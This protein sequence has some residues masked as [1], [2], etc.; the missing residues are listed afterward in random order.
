MVQKLVSDYFGREAH[1]RVNPDEV[2]ALGAA[3]QGGVL[4][5][6][7]TDILLLDVTPLSLG[8]ETLGGVMTRLIERNTT[9]PVRKEEIFSTATDSQ[10]SV[11][12]H[13]L[14]GEREMAVDNR[15][16]G[17]FNLDGIPPAPRGVPQIVVTFDIDANGIVHVSAR[18][19]ATG[20]EQRIRIEAGSGLSESEIDRMVDDAKHHEAE[21]KK[22]REVIEARNQ[23]DGLVYAT[24][25]SLKEHRDK[26]DDAVISNIERNLEA[27]K[28]LVEQSS[29]DIDALKRAREEL[30]QA[31]H[32][33]AEVMYQAAAGAGGP[34]GPGAAAGGPQAAGGGAGGDDEGDV[35]DADFEEAG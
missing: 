24:E 2:V 33:M 20:N 19:K 9:I 6:D 14:Q 15:T 5:G 12:V 26:L 8:I 21:D 27:A 3:V 16:L 28:K 7:V 29:S 22:R 11:T 34:G 35:I 13:V 4:S 17:K 18:D 10:T 25:R 32:K 31:A 23:L 30:E 1:K